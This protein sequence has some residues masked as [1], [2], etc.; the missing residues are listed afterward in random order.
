MQLVPGLQQ[1]F[2]EALDDATHSVAS[3]SAMDDEKMRWREAIRCLCR[4]Y[5]V[6]KEKVR[7]LEVVK[8]PWAAQA[9]AHGMAED[10]AQQRIARLYP[11]QCQFDPDN[12][13]PGIRHGAVPEDKLEELQRLYDWSRQQ[14]LHYVLDQKDA[15][16]RHATV[17]LVLPYT[18][19]IIY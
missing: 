17:F 8:F 14:A 16:R 12:Y 13:Q 1:T 6:P 10:M 11:L 7:I 2:D 5:G 3:Y 18:R 19:V 4:R 9:G 15:C